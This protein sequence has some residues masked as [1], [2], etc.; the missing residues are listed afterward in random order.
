MSKLVLA[1]V[2]GGAVIGAMI[3]ASRQRPSQTAGVIPVDD[4]INL[5]PFERRKGSKVVVKEERSLRTTQLQPSGKAVVIEDL[6]A[7]PKL[8]KIL[9]HARAEHDRASVERSKAEEVAAK[10]AAAVAAATALR[11][12][13]SMD[14][15]QRERVE[16]LVKDLEDVSRGLP[17]R[18]AEEEG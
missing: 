11:D 14:A 9:E 12:R 8:R 13:E 4:E 5:E 7:D 10:A 1:A 3:A 15:E 6:N 2:A 17:S 16:K 18:R